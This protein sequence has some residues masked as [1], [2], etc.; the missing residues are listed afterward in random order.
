MGF[1]IRVDEEQRKRMER[2]WKEWN[3]R[4]ESG[5]LPVPVLTKNAL[6]RGFL[7]SG[8][9][10]YERVTGLRPPTPAKAKRRARR[11]GRRP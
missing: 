5:E 11:G 6:Y 8:C 9:L 7:A 4:A 2:I 3:K 1:A 10:E